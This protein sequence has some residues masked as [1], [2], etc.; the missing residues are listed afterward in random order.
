MLPIMRG[1]ATTLRGAGVTLVARREDRLLPRRVSA[2]LA[3]RLMV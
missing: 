3:H 2:A 1:V